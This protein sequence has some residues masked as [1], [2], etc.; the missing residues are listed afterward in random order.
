MWAAVVVACVIAAG[1]GYL[2]TTL[3]PGV[4]S[5]RMAALA[6]GGLIAMLTSSCWHRLRA[7]GAQAGIWTVVGLAVAAAPLAM[8]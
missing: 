8:S 2:L 4:S 1:V 5:Q 6:G 7:A 3:D